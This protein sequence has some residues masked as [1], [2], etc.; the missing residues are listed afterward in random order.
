[1]DLTM[2]RSLPALLVFT[3]AGL[4]IFFELGALPLIDPDEGRNAAI[5]RE[6]AAAGEWLVPTYGG[7]PYLDKPA[8]FFDL[9]RWHLPPP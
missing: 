9:E 8:F 4:L 5:A 3:L 6:M 2:H 1:M 7:L